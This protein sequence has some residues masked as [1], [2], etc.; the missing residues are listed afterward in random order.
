MS[1]DTDGWWSEAFGKTQR[2]SD[3]Q[4]IRDAVDHT[5]TLVRD[6][7]RKIDALEHSQRRWDRYSQRLGQKVLGV[8]GM[9][10]VLGGMGGAAV[11]VD[12]EGYGKFWSFVTVITVGAYLSWMT[13]QD[14]PKPPGD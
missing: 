7:S 1:E 10:L 2:P 9:I 13:S 8:A 12:H 3:P 14:V 6:L 11:W 5:H 4:A